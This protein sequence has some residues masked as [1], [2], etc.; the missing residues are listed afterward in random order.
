M[1][2]PYTNFQNNR[3]VFGPVFGNTGRNGRS[4]GQTAVTALNLTGREL[5]SVD[6]FY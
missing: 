5:K 1:G 3:N 2:Q 6:G 4:D